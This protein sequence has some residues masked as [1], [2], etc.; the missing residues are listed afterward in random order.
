MNPDSRRVLLS[1]LILTLCICLCLSVLSI[2]WA[3]AFLSGV[4]N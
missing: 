4:L 1:C 3:G 2:A